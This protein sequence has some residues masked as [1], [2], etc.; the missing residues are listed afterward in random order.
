MVRFLLRLTLFLTLLFA[1]AVA[2]AQTGS[3]WQYDFRTGDHLVYKYTVQRQTDADGAQSEV[4]AHYR[5]HVLVGSAVDGRVGIGFQRNRESAEMTGY[6]VKGKDRLP[7][8]RPAFLKRMAA[9]PSRF[10][11]AMVLSLAGESQLPWEIARES[12]SHIVG[13]I[14]EVMNLPVSAVGEGQVWHGHDLA[15][16]DARWVG[17]ETIHGKLCHH[18]E[19]ASKDISLK[20]S[21]WWSPEDGVLEKI[22][23]EGSYANGG[24]TTREELGMELESRSRGE[25]LDT[26]LHSSETREGALQVLLLDPAVPVSDAQVTTVLDGDD[27]KSQ[28]LALAIARARRLSLSSS[29]VSKLSQNSNDAIRELAEQVS[30]TTKGETA[31]QDCGQPL[32]GKSPP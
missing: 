10:S 9:R 28:G 27:A 29:L 21:Y 31:P 17:D 4:E 22:E 11:E 14:H 7:Q 6:R 15:A 5:T 30:G 3:T 32:P 8:E 2:T 20:L 13:A 16:L 25:T 19:A 12:P 24:G 26:W 23:M 1:L 18:I